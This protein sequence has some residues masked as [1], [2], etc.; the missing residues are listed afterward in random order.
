MAKNVR[1]NV[2]KKI[3]TYIDGETGEQITEEEFKRR[4][5]KIAR[6]NL[7]KS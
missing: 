2:T 4:Y 6:L 7:G 5:S 1:I 3:K